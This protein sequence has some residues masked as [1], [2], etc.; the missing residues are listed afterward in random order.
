MHNKSNQISVPLNYSWH[1]L[2]TRHK[3]DDEF[4]PVSYSS[5]S[6]S[7]VCTPISKMAASKPAV[8]STDPPRQERFEI[9][10]RAN[11]EIEPGDARIVVGKWMRKLM[12]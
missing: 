12:G 3:V 9:W 5:H 6:S 4:Q 10:R 1:V 8:Y 11:D 7:I 2:H